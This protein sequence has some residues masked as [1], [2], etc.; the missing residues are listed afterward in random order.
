MK[1]NIDEVRKENLFLL[2]AIDNGTISSVSKS[3]GVARST[4]SGVAN[5]KA[6][7]IKHARAIEKALDKPFGWMD[8][9]HS[10]N[11]I[12]P[13]YTK[14]ALR[15]SID[16]IASYKQIG[17]LYAELDVDGKTDLMDKLYRLF[18]DPA[19]RELSAE[20][21]SIMLGITNENSKPVKRN[22]K[23]N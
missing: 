13:H 6:M 4:L 16:C 17:K 7:L 23:R 12:S 3:T 1:P 20:S 21:L 14:K 19:A 5:G 18:A 11:E 8:K 15:A 2:M 9:P 10:D 22:S